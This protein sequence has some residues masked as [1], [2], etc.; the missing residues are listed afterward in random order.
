MIFL[1]E[2]IR[3][4]GA[5]AIADLFGG[6]PGVAQLPLFQ[7]GPT[8]HQLAN[9]E[10]DPNENYAVNFK[11][12]LTN[13]SDQALVGQ[14]VDISLCRYNSPGKGRLELTKL[15]RRSRRLYWAIKL[16]H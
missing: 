8:L 10:E 7:G 16:K 6:E 13:L 5:A 14:Q 2:Y 11:L 1:L 15:M 3:T 9:P 4:N 12:V